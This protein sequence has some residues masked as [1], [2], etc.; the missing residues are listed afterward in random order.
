[1]AKAT[2]FQKLRKRRQ[3]NILLRR[4]FILVA[5]VV[6]LF[7]VLSLNNLLV[8]QQFPTVVNNFI[9]GFGGSRFPIRAPGGI[10]RD[11]QP[12]GN[13][14][15]VLNNTNLHVYN[16]NGRELL[17]VQHMSDSTVM[18]TSG[19]RM[20]TYTFGGTGFNIYFQNRMMLDG[21]HDNP[22]RVAA[23]GERGN[24]ALVSST[25][26]FASQVT[27]FTEQFEQHVR[28][29]TSELVAMVALNPRGTEMAAASIGAQ[30]G[31]LRTT[32]SLFDFSTSSVKAQL[33]LTGE[34][35]LGL[36]Y[37]NDA[38]IAVITDG[39]LRVINSANGRVINSYD[40]SAGRLVL[41]R[42]NSEHILLLN[43]N[44]EYRTQTVILFNTRGE[45]LGRTEPGSMVRDMQVGSAGVYV[46][47]AQGIGRYDHTM[48]HIEKVEQGGILRILLA[49]NTLYYFTEEEIRVLSTR[50][51][52]QPT[53]GGSPGD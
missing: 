25:W 47:T 7:A 48:S 42:M 46:L 2:D 28:W 5:V 15:V 37:L 41:T 20:L 13:D 38:H 26:Q 10:L 1:M 52:N 35:I 33:E 11:V 45:E 6:A 3:R 4:L 32:I 16:R 27:V 23:L 36:E 12:L 50:P 34:L 30:G 39:G 21:E 19:N 40:I 31:Q 29:D 22:I 18:L 51:V 17:G 44:S 24:Y 8:N 14:I 43:E 53:R 9:Q 49:G